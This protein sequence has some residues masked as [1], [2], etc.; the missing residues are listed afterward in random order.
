MYFPSV[1]A[2]SHKFSI[3]PGGELLIGSE[4]SYGVQKWHGSPLWGL[5]CNYWWDYCCRRKSVS[6]FSFFVCF[7]SRFWITKLV[8][9]ET[10]LSSAVFRTIMALLYRISFLCT[11]IQ[12]FLWITGF[13]IGAYF[14]FFSV[15]PHDFSLGANLFIQKYHFLVILW[16]VSP[17]RS[18]FAWRCGPETLSVVSGITRT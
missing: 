16:A 13:Y 2:F 14:N 10:L 15:N 11:Y 17:Q 6:S 7:L 12:V 1:G 3:A 18:I 4:K 9:K 8:I 5:L